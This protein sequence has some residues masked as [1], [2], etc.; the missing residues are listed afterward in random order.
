M[1]MSKRVQIRMDE[2]AWEE[3]DRSY[4][5]YCSRYGRVPKGEFFERLVRLGLG[6]LSK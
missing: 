1:G 2:G 5:E 4:A 3:F 6:V